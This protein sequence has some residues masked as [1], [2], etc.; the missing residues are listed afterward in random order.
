MGGLIK[1]AFNLKKF[2]QDVMSG[3]S[4]RQIPVQFNVTGK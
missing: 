4:S 3:T 1:V 2:I